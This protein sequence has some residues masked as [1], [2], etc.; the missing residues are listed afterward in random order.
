MIFVTIGSMAPFDRLI[1]RADALA[2]RL[3]NE[4]FVAQIGSGEYWPTNM[5]AE[6]ML[7]TSA[8][9]QNINGAKLVVAHAGMGSVISAMEASVPIVIVPRRQSLGE[10]NTDHQLATARWLQGRS[11]VH[12]ALDDGDLDHVVIS[13]LAETGREREVMS[14]TAPQPFID[15]L[16]QY[17]TEA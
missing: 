3:P 6:R 7:K 12:V 9:R 15:K 17:L 4:R 5:A 11:G 8:F 13:A 10:V 2:A 16:R 14:S 1:R